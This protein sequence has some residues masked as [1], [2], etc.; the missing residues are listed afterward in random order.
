VLTLFPHHNGRAIIR[1]LADYEL[2]LEEMQK[3][4][5]EQKARNLLINA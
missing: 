3:M 1:P 4:L 5:D 2:Q